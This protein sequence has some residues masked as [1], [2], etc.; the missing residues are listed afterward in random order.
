MTEYEDMLIEN[1][2][3]DVKRLLDEEEELHDA[4]ILAL[5]RF[6]GDSPNEFSWLQANCGGYAGLCARILE[7]IRR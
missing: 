3:W 5:S 4:M 2:V 6:Q 7:K 1:I